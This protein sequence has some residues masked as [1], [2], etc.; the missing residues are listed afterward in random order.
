MKL[1]LTTLAALAIG[2]FVVFA[3]TEVFAG[4]IYLIYIICIPIAIVDVVCSVKKQRKKREWELKQYCYHL[5]REG[6][7]NVRYA[8]ATLNRQIEDDEYKGY[9]VD[10][11]KNG[12]D[13][14]IVKTHIAKVNKEWAEWA[15]D[16]G[17][18]L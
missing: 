6:L 7:Y 14:E 12:S 1:I 16:H 11:E 2:A 4:A 3:S 17:I 5:N 13:G 8:K 15:N 9:L 18:K 10:Y